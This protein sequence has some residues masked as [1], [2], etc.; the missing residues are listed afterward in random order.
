MIKEILNKIIGGLVNALERKKYIE[1]M[2]TGASR[3]ASP[4]I[5]RSST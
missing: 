3:Y 2:P 4:L 5:Y 1:G